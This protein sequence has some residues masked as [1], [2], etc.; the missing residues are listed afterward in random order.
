MQAGNIIIQR[1]CASLLW[2]SNEEK[3]C[4]RA[5]AEVIIL[6]GSLASSLTYYLGG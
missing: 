4:W 5:E 1:G 2:Q 6:L 3:Q